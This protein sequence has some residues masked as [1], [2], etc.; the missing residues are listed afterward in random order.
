VLVYLLVLS[1]LTL[2]ADPPTLDVFYPAGAARGSTN[3]ITLSGKLDPWPPNVWISSPQ[4]QSDWSRSGPAIAAADISVTAETNKGKLTLVVSPDAEP[5]PRIVRLFNGDGASDPRFFVV[6]AGR[7]ISEA[8]T[9]NHFARPQLVQTLPITINGRLTKGGD[10][11]SFGISLRD[12]EV[13]EARVESYTLMSKLDGVLRLVA[14]N[15]QQ[16]AWNHDFASLDPLL[17]WRAPGDQNVVLQIFGF[18]HPATADIR[19]YGGDSAFYRLHLSHP[20]LAHDPALAPTNTLPLPATLRGCLTSNTEEDRFSFTAAKDEFIE[21][22]IT[23]AALGSP[24]DPWLAICDA[25]GKELSRSDDNDNSRDPVIEWKAP[26]NGVYTAVVG[27]L[28]HRGSD[29][30]RYE[31][32]IKRVAADFRA[33][34]SSGSLTVTDGSTNVLKFKVRRLRDHTN[35]LTAAL[36]GLP[37]GV[38]ASATNIAAKSGDFEIPLIAATNAPP[39]SGP[40]HLYLTDAIKRE[41]RLAPFPLTSRTEDN[42]VPGGYTDLVIDTLDHCWLT[43]RKKPDEPPKTAAAK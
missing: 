24:L 12:G 14:T 22:R 17:T 19:L 28:T 6:G 5:G 10:V 18:P 40:V 35:D 4:R 42:G 39:Y 34:L 25:N 3:T 7:E 30:H 20:A 9:N 15:G 2:H 27:S 31:L 11:D 37:P 1:M 41:D 33:S 21:A 36:S 38:T 16:L 29:Q 43:V 23:A 8:E 26:T 13:L 32:G